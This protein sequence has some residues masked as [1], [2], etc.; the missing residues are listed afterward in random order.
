MEKHVGE[1]IG[2]LKGNT[3]GKHWEPGKKEKKS[4]PS[5]PP[6]LS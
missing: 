3:M 5:S 2:N 4:F 6:P 1:P